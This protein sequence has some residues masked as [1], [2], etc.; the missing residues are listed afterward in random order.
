[1]RPILLLRAL[2]L[3]GLGASA[4]HR[5]V[6]AEAPGGAPTVAPA[7]APIVAP[8]AAVAPAAVP[9]R[10]DVQRPEIRAFITEQAR[11]GVMTAAQ[12]TQLLGAAQSQPKILEAM[13]RPAEK[14]LQWYEYRARFITDERIEAGVAVWR[15]HREAL[16]RAASREQVAPQYIVAILGVETFYGR[17]TGRYRVIDALATLAFDYPPRQ[18]YFRAELAQFLKLC[19]EEGL[20]ALGLQGSYAGAMGVAQF[21][22]SSYRQYAL[23]EDG[24]PARDLWR[25]WGDIF[26][27]VGHYLHAYGWQY[28]APV[29]ADA[30]FTGTL[31]PELPTTVSLNDTVGKLRERGFTTDFPVAAETPAVAVAAPEAGQPAYRIGFKNFYVIT[32]YNRS[33]LYAMA[34]NDLAD[35]IVRRY[36]QQ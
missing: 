22:P 1:M 35:A 25:D 34:V 29:M 30:R 21:M 27:S 13:E 36:N 2:L 19:S 20:D 11:S 15:E 14:A 16:E 10:F 9:S 8:A 4:A 17:N 24:S 18:A 12:L 6:A 7:A 33:P 31:P 28:G 32:R 23:N 26:A 5:A 3:T